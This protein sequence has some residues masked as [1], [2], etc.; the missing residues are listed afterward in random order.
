MAEALSQLAGTGVVGALLVVCMFALRQ[1]DKELSD[2]KAS[3]IK[4]AQDYT[5]LAM[6]LQKEVIIAV[7]KLSEIVD[8]WEKREQE[9][10]RGTPVRSST[11]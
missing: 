2:E 10:L 8:V 6:S 9:R 5:T 7:T 11:R 4:D 1:K 3:R